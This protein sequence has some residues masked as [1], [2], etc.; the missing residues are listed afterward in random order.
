MR[1]FLL[2]LVG[3]LLIGNFVILIMYGDTLQSTN[4]FIV[5]GTV[6]YPV[7]FI[8]LIAGILL[9]ASVIWQWFTQKRTS[10]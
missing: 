1:N 8:N 7:A 3:M 9:I 6:F 5:R 4:L 2:L 10:G